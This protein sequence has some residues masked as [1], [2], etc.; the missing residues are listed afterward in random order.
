MTRR[1]RLPA[2]LTAALLLAGC[3]RQVVP[4]SSLPLH[5]STAAAATAAGTVTWALYRDVDSLDPAHA[6]DY[7]ENTV[8]SSMCEA[9]ERQQPDGAITAGLAR[10]TYRT[11]R[12]IMLALHPGVR[13][14]DGSPMTSADVVYSLERQ[15]NPK[16][17]G[18][19]GTVF[20]RVKSIRARGRLTVEIVLRRADYWL[21]GELSAMP[22]V[23][24]EK[25][26]AEAKGQAYGTPSGGAMCTGP[27]ELKRWTP[28]AEVDVVANHHYWNPALRPRAAE[29]RFEGISD[30]AA[31]TAALRT[32]AIDGTYLTDTSNL[33][34]LLKLSN[35]RVY[36]G[37]SFDTDYL[38]ISNLE[39]P[40]GDVRIRRALSLAF[41]RKVYIDTVYDGA[42]QIPRL[43]ANP[44]T[45]G[46]AKGVFRR[47]WDHQPPLTQNLARA[48][49]LIHAAGAQGKTIVIATCSGLA[50]VA[51]EADAWQAAAESIGLRARLQN[52]SPEDYIALFTDPGA[53]S[54]IDAFSTTTYG[55][56]ADPA[57]L[58]STYAMPHQSQN[59][60]GY[61]N[62]RLNALFDAARAEADP[63]RRAE[64]DVAAERLIMREL[65]WIPAADPDTLLVLG[66]H[67]S[68]PPSSF[69]YM[70]AP[71]LARV[72]EAE[73]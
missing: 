12:R 30:T 47:A 39:G 65:P 58:D 16:I 51:T 29:I 38:I 4:V 71:W 31:L 44:G 41:D 60:D 8:I 26:Y 3:G 72:G 32:G 28:G 63:R 7:P 14:W 6:F 20:D 36:A 17:A 23:I 33:A 66:R 42:A 1:A 61:D 15:M 45:W 18:F 49:R 43:S 27:F 10:L 68:G 35:V 70:Q 67:L 5:A 59:F 21:A 34:Q 9:L 11:P 53:R 22:G 40:L 62:P 73:H 13:F 24:I 19:Y 54:G 64:L 2:V 57:A 56:Y 25:R 46:F 69:A 48:R 55:D 52:V 50:S 37:P